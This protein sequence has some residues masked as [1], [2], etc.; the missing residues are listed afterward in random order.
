MKIVGDAVLFLTNDNL[1][2]H[3][4]MGL[5]PYT[6]RILTPAEYHILTTGEITKIRIDHSTSEEIKYF[7]RK[8]RSIYALGEL[9]GHLLVGIAWI[10]EEE[11]EHPEQ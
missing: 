11:K 9:L 5:K 4:E 2:R 6:V 10:H 8:I 1:F 7:E 3:E